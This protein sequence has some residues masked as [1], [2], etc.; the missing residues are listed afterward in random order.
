MC[1]GVGR[2]LVSTFLS[3]PFQ[4][5]T[6]AETSKSG[7][8]Y[9]EPVPTPLFQGAQRCRVWALSQSPWLQWR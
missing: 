4:V 3:A 9:L 1:K 5:G 6:E 2:G 7:L 8:H